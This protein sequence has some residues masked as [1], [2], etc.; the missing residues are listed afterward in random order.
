MVRSGAPSKLARGFLQQCQLSWHC[1]RKFLYCRG[2]VVM[3][4]HQVLT[5]QPPP[6]PSQTQRNRNPTC[7]T[8]SPLNNGNQKQKMGAM[9]FRGEAPEPP[10]HA[11]S[12]F[13]QKPAAAF[14]CSMIHFPKRWCY[15]AMAQ[16]APAPT[17]GRR[18]RDP[19]TGLWR[20]PQAVPVPR[21][22]Q[23]RRQQRQAASASSRGRRRGLGAIAG[24]KAKTRKM[25]MKA[26]VSS[27]NKKTIAQA[28]AGII[29]MQSL[30]PLSFSPSGRLCPT[31]GRRECG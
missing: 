8:P 12:P 27:P 16:A 18:R 25:T 5:T 28:K 20:R 22:G 29:A 30:R 31:R 19:A 2:Q 15:A 24:P 21:R 14:F 1:C 11:M 17:R 26:K 3:E 6:A 9:A 10:P 13:A 23:R 4:K 7:L